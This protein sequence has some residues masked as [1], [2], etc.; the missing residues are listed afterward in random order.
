MTS[1]KVASGST[2]ERI[3]DAALDLFASE[4]FGGTSISE[5][6]R[7]VGLAAGTGSFYRHFQSKEE[8][9]QVAVEREVDS[10]MADI[11]EA[12]AAASV[13]P[14]PDRAAELQMMLRDI[15]RFDRLFRLL[16]TEGDRVPGVRD[17][18]TAA[19][20]GPG[21]A[22]SWE[23]RPAT[24][25]AVTALTGYHLLELL[26]GHPFQDVPEDEFVAALAEA[27]GG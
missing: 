18:I 21:E 13:E 1:R 12:R 3:L 15:R 6:E 27:T 10:C 8:L 11:V 9:L 19:L 5:I 16:M 4:G 14:A 24:V 23:T 2:R 22:V 25:I 20:R 17:A 26:H 7:R